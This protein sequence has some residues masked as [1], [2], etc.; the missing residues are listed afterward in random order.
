MKL[1]L[2]V[3]ILVLAGCASG[4]PLLEYGLGSDSIELGNTPFFPQNEYQC[5]PAALATVLGAD[6][7]E[8]SPEALVPNIYLPG[9]R[10][11]LQA[12]IVATTRRYG[13]MP[14][15]LPPDLHAL[16]TEVEAGTP[17]LVMQNL[18]LKIFPQWH[19]AV[20]IGYDAAADAL[21]LRSGT[22]E[23]LSMN[24]VRFQGS[25]ARAD[26]WAMVA[27]LP[28]EPPSTAQLA[29]WLRAATDFEELGKPELALQAYEAAS[30][31]WPERPLAWQALANSRYSRGDL[32]AAEAALRQALQLAPSAAAHNNLA[33]VLQK[34]GCLTAARSEMALAEGMADAAALTAVLARTRAAIALDDT[35]DREEC[36]AAT[37]AASIA[38]DPG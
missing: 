5:G 29:N 38:A 6:G 21:L 17:V 24:R 20:V 18:G 1:L 26:N 36:S 22:E 15:I 7:L 32:A 28:A 3:S 10:G 33:H 19:Y 9:R 31:R 30:G 25:W 35:P 27:V 8:V 37:A 34:R 2:L 23:R 4:P 14:Y 11:S 12:E 13:R 16:L